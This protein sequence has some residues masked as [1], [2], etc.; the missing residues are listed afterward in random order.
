MKASTTVLWIALAAGAA[1]IVPASAATRTNL[2]DPMLPEAGTGQIFEGP[3]PGLSTD[4]VAPAWRDPGLLNLA[5]TEVIPVPP[6]HL[7]GINPGSDIGAADGAEAPMPQSRPGTL[8][9][10]L[11]PRDG[12]VTPPPTGDGEIAVA[13]PPVPNTM[14]VITPDDINPQ[15][16]MATPVLPGD[17]IGRD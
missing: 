13:P 9:E 5:E 6:D 17:G 4:D 2:A 8:T 1:T 16:G 3:I 12:V 11:E 14:P 7:P 10:T 15:S